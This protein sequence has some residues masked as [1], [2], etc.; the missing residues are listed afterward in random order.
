MV[1]SSTRN[2]KYSTAV[3]QA[4]SGLGH[5]TNVELLDVLQQTYPELSATTVH[6]ITARLLASGDIGRA[7][8]NLSGAMRFDHRLDQHDNF[9]CSGCQG[10]RDIDVAE[11]VLPAINNALGE[12]RVTGR[13]VIY[14][15]CEACISNQ[16]KSGEEV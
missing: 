9:I 7:P 4:L 12:C 11:Q 14:G 5:A 13:L 6:R 3:K 8:Q 10:M 16:P 2:T 15:S 1:T